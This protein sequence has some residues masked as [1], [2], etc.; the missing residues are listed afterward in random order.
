M[1]HKI[2]V[3]L[4][5]DFKGDNNQAKA[6][7][8]ALKASLDKSD[9]DVEL[10]EGLEDAVSIVEE[11]DTKHYV[12]TA[13][14]HGLAKASELKGSGAK[15]L[16]ITTAH[17]H[18]DLMTELD[19]KLMPDVL[20]LPQG[21][22]SDAQRAAL[23]PKTRLVETF[24]VPHGINEKSLLEATKELEFFK[25]DAFKQNVVGI[26]LAGDAPDGDEI[27]FFTP[28]EAEEKAA[29]IYQATKAHYAK[30][31]KV[32]DENTLFFVTNGPR[33]GK[34]NYVTKALLDP[35]P[36][37]TDVL[38]ATSFAFT[39]ALRKL[40]EADGLNPGQ[41]MFEDFKSGKASAYKPMLRFLIDTQGLYFVPAEST[42]MVTEASHP[43]SQGVT[44]VAYRPGSENPSHT[45]HLDQCYEMG[46]LAILESDGELKARKAVA[47]DDVKVASVD[48]MN[49]VYAHISISHLA[50][51]SMMKK[52]G[53]NKVSK[54][55]FSG[56]TD[57]LEEQKTRRMKMPQKEVHPNA[58][59]D[60]FAG[61]STE[62]GAGHDGKSVLSKAYDK[63]PAMPEGVKK[64]MTRQN[65]G[66]AAAGLAVFGLFAVACKK[67]YVSVPS[68]SSDP[69]PSGPSK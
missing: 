62:D 45:A 28:E 48:I 46:L 5:K 68:L 29:R 8:Q 6:V 63:L 22:L 59:T 60:K 50:Q 30:L 51:A 44:V 25:G 18:F 39:D 43:A 23:N 49:A 13:G 27:R 32:F 33:T 47:S 16:Y 24:G 57:E 26:M 7:G 3:L 9:P 55:S 37:E 34:H 41:L 65:A 35:N 12:I 17:M 69:T 40:M 19:A 4:N 56:L 67:G 10:V 53:L 20:A 52:P 42:S 66:Y 15:A 11:A 36:H 58:L 14:D 21:V 54:V 31:D 2:H 1:K 38:D 61:S 64:H